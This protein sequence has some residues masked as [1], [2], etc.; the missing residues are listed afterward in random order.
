MYPLLKDEIYPPDFFRNKKILVTGA[1]GFIGTH[2]CRR[3]KDLG[4]EVHGVSRSSQ[5]GGPV[6]RWWQVNLEN[7]DET[8]NLVDTVGADIIF[9]LASFVVGKRQVEY[10]LPMLQSNL[11][12]SINLLVAADGSGC[13]RIIL[14]GSLEE[15]E[16]DVAVAVPTSPYAAAKGASS[17]YA[18]M[19][20]ALYGTPVVTAR[21]F[22]VYGPGQ[23]DHSKLL[24]YVT[25]SL[26]RGQSPQ[27]MSG[28]REVDWI[29]VADVVEGYLALAGREGIDGQ[30]MDIGSGELVSVRNVVDQVAEIIGPEIRP[31]FGSL[32]DRPLERVR[33][34]DVEHS[35]AVLGWKPETGLQQGL[36]QTVEWYRDNAL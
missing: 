23:G 31:S 30:T 25:L 32:E 14:T 19:F 27:L 22:M 20:Y 36:Q 7:S 5:Q 26:L 3:L 21:L 18:R 4:A 28:A 6:S 35:S 17:S 34:A 11:L 16:G 9:H 8:A 29:Y 10:V 12:S 1:A 33:V 2:L 24:P 13:E 15:A